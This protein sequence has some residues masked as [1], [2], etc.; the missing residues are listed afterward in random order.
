MSRRKEDLGAVLS[1]AN[2]T[3]EVRSAVRA[4]YRAAR[5]LGMS[6]FDALAQAQSD[7][8]VRAARSNAN[9]EAW[10]DDDAR[11]T[12]LA[13][14]K[15]AAV[16]ATIAE[17]VRQHYVTN[18]DAR[19]RSREAALKQHADPSKRARRLEI[20]EKARAAKIERRQP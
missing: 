5:R 14:I 16:R 15:S 2:A 20:L 18:P 13:A 8:Q 19:E 9:K 11:E 4:A 1:V 3:S 12:R 17:S 7:D 10:Q 6:H